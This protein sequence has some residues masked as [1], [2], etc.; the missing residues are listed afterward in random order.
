M[1][2]DNCDGN[3][4]IEFP[5]ELNQEDVDYVLAHGGVHRDDGSIDISDFEYP[6]E[7]EYNGN[8]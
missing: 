1:K 7:E 4:Y 6:D 3:N 5:W 8:K 2:K